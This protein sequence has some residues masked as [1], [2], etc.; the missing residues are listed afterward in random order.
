MGWQ[1]RFIPVEAVGMTVSCNGVHALDWSSAEGDTVKPVPP[2]FATLPHVHFVAE[3][4]PNGRNARCQILRDGQFVHNME[5]DN[6]EDF[7]S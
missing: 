3:G 7:D 6:G 1:V 2:Q 4:S 5:F